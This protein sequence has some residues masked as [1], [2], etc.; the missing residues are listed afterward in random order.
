MKSQPFAA[1]SIAVAMNPLDRVGERRI[2]F[3]VQ[4]M[5][6]GPQRKWI[7]RP[8]RDDQI[9]VETYGEIESMDAVIGE[10][11]DVARP[12]EILPYVGCDIRII[13][14]N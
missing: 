3:K 10:I 4:A 14:N 11:E 5:D 6:M 8:I 12:R 9:K 13:F 1:N 2:S 7:G